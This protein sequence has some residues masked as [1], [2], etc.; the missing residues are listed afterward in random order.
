MLELIPVEGLCN[1]MRAIDSAVSF[2]AAYDIPLKVYW[3]RDKKLINCQFR[4]LFEPIK[5]LNLYEMDDLPFK[6]KQ[7]RKSNFFLP[8]ILRKL[9]Y[10]GKIFRQFDI[11]TFKNQGGD[12][13]QLYDE[14]KR[15]VLFSFSRFFA[16]EKPYDIF[17][18][19]PLVQDM[20]AKETQDFNE[21][22]IG[23]HI[24]RTD[25]KLAIKNSPLGLFELKIEEEIA[26]DTRANFYVASD[27]STTKKYL[28]DKYGKA[29]HTNFEPG[30]R[31]TLKG[32]YRA[33]TELY[34]L[35][36]T[37][38]IYGSYG[39]SFSGTACIL[40]GIERIQVQ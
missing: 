2:C 14:H 11:K 16:T 25:H 17:Q 28:V 15:L 21:Y 35:S 36:K 34:T 5:G 39:S 9:P 29:I 40:A 38:K 19:I 7:G 8:N 33:I 24:R 37:H 23:V 31:T 18:P 26:K 1:K 6:L 10:A 20:I 4:D 27:C 12:F 32:M 30:D 13:K 3:I 22:T